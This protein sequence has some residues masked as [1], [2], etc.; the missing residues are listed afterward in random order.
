MSYIAIIC[1]LQVLGT[2][3][4]NLHQVVTPSGE[5]FLASLP[6]KFRKNIWIKRGDYVVTEAIHEGD[7][8]KGE[9]VRILYPQHIKAIKKE[10]M[11]PQEF[12]KTLKTST[13]NTYQEAQF[14][15][16]PSADNDMDSIGEDSEEDDFSD[17]PPNTNRPPEISLSET[18][19]E[20]SSDDE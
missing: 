2:A 19:E 14:S 11:W 8:V 13:M 3:G 10:N 6:T 20:T 9:I 4:C 17:I 5:A 16:S 12:D 7:K 18:D 15:T 1:M